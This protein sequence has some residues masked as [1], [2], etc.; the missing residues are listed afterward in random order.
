MESNTCLF[1]TVCRGVYPYLGPV[2]INCWKKRQAG[3]N[4]GQ[5]FVCQRAATGVVANFKAENSAAVW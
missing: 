4:R 1:A 5:G 3:E 2:A